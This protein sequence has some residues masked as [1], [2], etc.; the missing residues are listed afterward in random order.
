MHPRRHKTLRLLSNFYKA[1]Q[2]CRLGPKPNVA[3]GGLTR[4]R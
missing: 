3:P 1:A 2:K 4:S